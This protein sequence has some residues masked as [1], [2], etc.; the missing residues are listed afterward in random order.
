MVVQALLSLLRCKLSPRFQQ[1]LTLPCALRS[2]CGATSPGWTLCASHFQS[3][4][5]PSLVSHHE[6]IMNMMVIFPAFISVLMLS[7]LFL[8]FFT[9]HEVV[10]RSKLTEWWCASVCLCVW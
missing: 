5:G 9:G 8:R 2:G 7:G 1:S 4:S 3:L 10:C 6:K